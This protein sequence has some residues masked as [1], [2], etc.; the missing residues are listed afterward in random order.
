MHQKSMQV[1][2]KFVK[3]PNWNEIFC[4]VVCA[5]SI[6]ES[7]HVMYVSGILFQKLI[8]MRLNIS[9]IACVFCTYLSWTLQWIPINGNGIVR[10]LLYETHQTDGILC[11]YN[12]RL[13]Y[14]ILLLIKNRNYELAKIYKNMLIMKT[15]KMHWK[16]EKYWKYYRKKTGSCDHIRGHINLLNV[17]HNTSSGAK[18]RTVID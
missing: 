7:D 9:N 5:R 6:G 12:G 2:C 17:M 1:K 10:N 13:I 16:P 8:Y 11:V 3:M 14:Y 18:W 15:Q 4:C